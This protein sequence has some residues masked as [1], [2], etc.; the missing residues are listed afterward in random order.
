MSVANALTTS[1]LVCLLHREE[2]SYCK[3]IQSQIYLRIL[4][5]IIIL[6]IVIIASKTTTTEINVEKS[7]LTCK[8]HNRNKRERSMS[9]FCAIY[10]FC[11]IF[12]SGWQSVELCDV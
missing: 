6:K 11:V 8:D 10:A 1:L 3:T 2:T 9:S 4:L 12:G 5:K 7:V